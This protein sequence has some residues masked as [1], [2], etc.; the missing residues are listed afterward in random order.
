M[1]SSLNEEERFQTPHVVEKVTSQSQETDEDKQEPK[2][3]FCSF[4]C[5]DIDK[6]MSKIQIF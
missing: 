5:K 3:K 2:K 1:R 6:N 4:C